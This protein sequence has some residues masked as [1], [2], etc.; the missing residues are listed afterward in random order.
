MGFGGEASAARVRVG[1]LG[2]NRP[3]IGHI[4][5]N[6]LAVATLNPTRHKTR[7]WWLNDAL[8]SLCRTYSPE[9][10]AVPLLQQ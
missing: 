3:L 4:R 8:L 6:L 1:G 10:R 7:P 5:T 9:V 2:A